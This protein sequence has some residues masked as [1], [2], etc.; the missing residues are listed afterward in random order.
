MKRRC[1]QWLRYA[2]LPAELTLNDHCCHACAAPR[3]HICS[4]I[5]GSIQHTCVD[6]DASLPRRLSHAHLV[7]C[8]FLNLLLLVLHCFLQVPDVKPSLFWPWLF[9]TTS[10]SFRVPSMFLTPFTFRICFVIS[11]LTH[12]QLLKADTMGIPGRCE[13]SRSSTIVIIVTALRSVIAHGMC[14]L[15]SSNSVS[16]KAAL[17]F[18]ASADSSTDGEK[19]VGPC[20]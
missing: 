3:A 19:V 11:F 13:C 5:N 14:L 8:F 9:G 20:R 10:A 16:E 18:V 15:E 17:G 12:I 4:K 2:I 1:W 6:C 7:L